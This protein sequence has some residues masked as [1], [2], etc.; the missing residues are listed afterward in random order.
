MLK[1]KDFR[2]C[3]KTKMG[4]K[5]TKLGEILDF[6]KSISK[7]LNFEN[8]VPTPSKKDVFLNTSVLMQWSYA[9]MLIHKLFN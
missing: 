8:A 1:E 9:I 2:V 6:Q 4:T 5:N 3:L 7:K